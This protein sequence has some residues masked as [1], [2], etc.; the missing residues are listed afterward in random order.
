MTS[1][2]TLAE[3]LTRHPFVVPLAFCYFYAGLQTWR[4]MFLLDPSAQRCE[5]SHAMRSGRSMIL[6]FTLFML[7]WPVLNLI[8]F[9]NLQLVARPPRPAPQRD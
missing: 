7:T 2:A 4:L 9:I 1:L 5:L 6:P 3:F 8:A